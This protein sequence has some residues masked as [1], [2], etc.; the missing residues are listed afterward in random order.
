MTTTVKAISKHIR[1]FEQQLPRET[2]V[3]TRNNI[4]E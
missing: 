2:F 3:K 1:Q 4:D